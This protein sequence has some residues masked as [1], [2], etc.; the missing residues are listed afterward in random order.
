MSLEK[1][2][3]GTFCAVSFAHFTNHLNWLCFR[4]LATICHF[5]LHIVVW[6][7]PECSD[8]PRDLTRRKPGFYN[9]PD[10][11]QRPLLP[12][13][14]KNCCY[15]TC[16]VIF[17]CFLCVRWLALGSCFVCFACWLLV[18]YFHSVQGKMARLYKKEQRLCVVVSLKLS[19]WISQLSSR[20]E[21][22]TVNTQ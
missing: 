3:A 17:N 19:K 7:P 10:S 8:G 13:I 18:F 2:R 12:N 1:V 16:V 6:K 5:L 22:E 15:R 11:I 20:V 21:I 4:L 9:V 14:F